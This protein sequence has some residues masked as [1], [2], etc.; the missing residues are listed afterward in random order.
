MAKGFLKSDQLNII[1]T[2]ALSVAILAPTMP[3]PST[4]HLWPPWRA[5]G[6]LVFLISTIML[7]FVAI[8]FI[9][10]NEVMP[11][12][13]SVYT[14]VKESMGDFMSSIAGWLLTLEYWTWSVGVSSAFGTLF[15]ILLKDVS[16]INIT[17]MIPGRYALSPSGISPTPT[18]S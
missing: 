12:A 11:S 14:F 17:W 15:K 16:G 1:Q 2:T 5:S 3:C 18:S 6:P 10:F 13:G 7:G 4:W 8:S 9:K